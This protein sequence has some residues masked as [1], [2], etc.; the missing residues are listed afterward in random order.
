MPSPLNVLLIGGG[1]REHALAQAISRS[2]R[3]GTLFATDTSN[4]GIADLAEPVGVP[5]SKREI[6]RLQQFC[7]KNA[8]DLV[9][10]GPEDPLAEGW[11]DS[12]AKRLD[13]NEPRAV[14]GPRAAAARLEADK[15]YA[16]HV[17][18]HASVPTAEGRS[19]NDYEA[20][21]AYLESREDLQVIKAAGLAKGKGVIVPATEEQGLE[22]LEQIMQ[23]HA[24]GDAGK[25]VVIEERLEGREASVLALFDGRTM[26][27]LPPCQD[28]KRLRDGD[29]GPNTGGMGAYCPTPAI[30]DEIMNEIE[31]EILVPTIDALRRDGIDF[32][33]VLYAGVML[34]P[35]GP[36]VLEFNVRFGDP[37][38]QPLLARLDSDALELLHATATGTLDRCDVSWN[39]KPAVSLVLSA[40]GYPEAPRKGHVITGVEQADAIEAVSVQ[41]AG[42]KRDAS[43]D[44]V[45]DGG[46]VLTVT[47]LGDTMNDARDRAYAAAERIDFAG[48]HCRTDIA[49]AVTV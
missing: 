48:K 32:T 9:V 45:T 6:Y 28:H 26:L 3:L 24:F 38:C 8:I 43:G 33:G 15:A 4:P 25:T 44:L 40:A 36:R 23:N 13:S 22:A 21:R 39:P 1:G 27:V 35:A 16:K 10:I 42:V 2:P 37:E 49:A 29:A 5:A 41:L 34:T 14:F 18:R 31:A 19:F 17:M 12:L 46:R 7:D 30:T 47:A 11:A 20:A